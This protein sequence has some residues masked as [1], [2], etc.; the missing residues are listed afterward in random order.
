MIKYIDGDL[1]KQSDL[2]D[3]ILHGCNCY[4]TMG[5]GI[6]P[7]IK[8]KFPEAYEVDCATKK[9]DN[10]KLGTIS[11]TKNTNPIVC[12]IYSQF[13]YGGGRYGRI[14]LD[15]EALRS[16]LKLVKTNFSGKK[17]GCNRIGS[18]LAGG[19]WDVI[20]KIIEDELGDEDITVV[21][22]VPD[23]KK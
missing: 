21:N 12:N 3:V 2:F 14:D 23:G 22:W 13:G 9:G 20:E 15:Y 19:E 8:A 4:C 5:S 7:L 6:A 17:I 1:V 18:G 16:G 10:N 11:F